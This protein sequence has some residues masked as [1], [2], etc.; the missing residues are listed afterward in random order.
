MEELSW[1]SQWFAALVKREGCMLG[2][3]GLGMLRLQGGLGDASLAPHCALSPRP[4]PG[5][6]KQPGGLW[7]PPQERRQAG[8]AGE[9]LAQEDCM[10]S[11][12][13]GGCGQGAPLGSTGPAGGQL[14]QEEQAVDG[15]NDCAQQ[16]KGFRCS[17]LTGNPLKCSETNLIKKLLPCGVWL[18]GEL[19]LRIHGG[20]SDVD[21]KKKKKHI[22]L[23]RVFL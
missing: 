16:T 6:R 17:F 8:L 5:G 11:L 2:P 9:A 18:D 19:Q 13:L 15:G 20:H 7:R 14:H 1:P 12:L 4:A 22:T 23:N 10:G 21:L 3:E